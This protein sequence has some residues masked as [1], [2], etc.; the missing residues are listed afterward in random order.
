MLDVLVRGRRRIPLG[1]RLRGR[2]YP[3][4]L[5]VPSACSAG[6]TRVA[7]GATTTSKKTKKNKT[8]RSS[9]VVRVARY[10]N[11]RL[12]SLCLRTPSVLPPAYVRILLPIYPHTY[13]PAGPSCLLYTLPPASLRRQG[14]CLL[15]GAQLYAPAVAP[16]AATGIKKVL[17]SLLTNADQV[18]QMQILH[19][20]L[21]VSSVALS[22]SRVHLACCFFFIHKTLIT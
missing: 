15:H 13:P 5:A 11:L 4:V 7:R 16:A 18:R 17:G 22:P 1:P 3:G 20:F 8:G 2:V 21:K 6:H 19:I 10:S 14:V 9:C 12:L